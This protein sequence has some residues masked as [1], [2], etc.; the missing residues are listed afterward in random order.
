M[1]KMLI[2]QFPYIR[3]PPKIRLRNA[4]LSQCV[5]RIDLEKTN[6]PWFFL[7]CSETARR[8]GWELQLFFCLILLD[9]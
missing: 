9:F 1:K 7:L 3:F 4:L 2:I 5:R 8:M 6:F